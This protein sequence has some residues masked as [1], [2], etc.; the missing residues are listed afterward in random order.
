MLQK[1]GE[2]DQEAPKT[3]INSPPNVPVT[4]SQQELM[5][6]AGGSIATEEETYDAVRVQYDQIKRHVIALEVRNSPLFSSSFFFPEDW[7]NFSPLI[8][9]KKSVQLVQTTRIHLIGR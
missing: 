5:I 4:E 2:S 1:W 3:L 8:C 7:N 6:G 9:R